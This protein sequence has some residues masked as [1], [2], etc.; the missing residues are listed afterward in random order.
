MHTV[1][2]GAFKTGLMEGVVTATER[3]YNTVDSEIREQ[4]GEDY[5]H[6]SKFFFCF[7]FF[8]GFMQP[9]AIIKNHVPFSS[10]S[11]SRI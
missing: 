2:P 10:P 8:F 7:F 4:Y 1:E 6:A 3:H 9:K 11:K 5:L